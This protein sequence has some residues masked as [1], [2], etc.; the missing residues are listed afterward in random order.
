MSETENDWRAPILAQLR[1]NTLQ[2]DISGGAIEQWRIASGDWG[3]VAEL[4]KDQQLRWA[5]GWAVQYEQR[6]I[7]HACLA[8]RDRYLWLKTDVKRDKPELPSQAAVYPAASR[9]ERHTQD[10]FGIHF[11]G[12]PDSR[13]WTRHQ[14][15]SKHQ[16]PLRKEFPL[17]G[18]PAEVT[19]ADTDYQFV[20]ARGSGVYEIPVGPVHAGIIEPGHFRFQAVGETV[21]HLEE[22]LGY[23]HKG[24]E[25]LAEGR[26]PEAL[27]RLAG[28]ISGD[29]T[30]AHSW[31]ACR[32][33]ELAARVD[34]PPRA[35][36]IRGI[37]C[38]RERIANHL[39]DIGAICNDVGFAFAQMQFTRLREQWQRSQAELFGHRLLMDCLLPG[40][41]KSDLNADQCAAIADELKTL[42]AELDELLPAMDLNSSLEDRLL[43]TGY[44]SERT[45][46][47]FGCV[48]YVGR[49]S[50]QDVDVRRDAPY[51]PYDRLAV[52]VALEHQGDV[53]SRVWVRVKEIFASLKLI[54]QMLQLLPAGEVAAPWR[55]PAEHSEGLAM[56]EG[57]RGE[58]V[59]YVRFAADNTVDRFYPRD[60][61]Q[62]NWPAL[63]RIVLNN[64]VPDFPVCNKSVNGSYSG[65]DL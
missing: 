50:G 7:V 57:W 54:G 13:T 38:E 45:A 10:M 4:A 59:S 31:A 43:T 65:H 46:E 62:P 41:V 6:L 48:G 12:H 1:D 25:K 63:E 56:V 11:Q 20:K 53:A 27:A 64:I 37:L 61:S 16:H 47:L 60:P 5:A 9:S 32:A 21:L 17:Q 26:S 28:R 42:R 22:R 44:L 34:V 3:R 40:G 33:M 24:I 15:W 51:P 2:I 29:S 19:P 39:G 14:A 8:K 49:S 36:F 18:E 30:V 23:V 58:I 35:E 55:Q 52:K